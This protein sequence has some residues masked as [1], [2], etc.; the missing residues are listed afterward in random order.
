L[1]ILKTS[2][3]SSIPTVLQASNL[4]EGIT[5]TL[6]K[7][8]IEYAF[9]SASLVYDFT[10]NGGAIFNLNNMISKINNK[11]KLVFIFS[12]KDT[13][14]G[15]FAFFSYHKYTESSNAAIEDSSGNIF[16]T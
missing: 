4:L 8:Q 15:R 7:N 1:P 2:S 5:Y 16:S 9:N 12:T 10:S 14:V 13:S 3:D 6:D 11:E